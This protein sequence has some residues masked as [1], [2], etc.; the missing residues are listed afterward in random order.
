MNT[1]N[2][3]KEKKKQLIDV[4]GSSSVESAQKGGYFYTSA[5]GYE[6]MFTMDAFETLTSE[7]FL[8]LISENRYLNDK[9]GVAYGKLADNS[10][11]GFVMEIGSKEG[12]HFEAGQRYTVE[13]TENNGIG[14]PM[15][16]SKKI[17]CNERDSVLL[18]LECDRLPERF[19]FNRCQSVRIELDSVSGIY[20][21]KKA[22]ESVRGNEGVYILRGSVV[23]FRHIY[24][25]YEG[26]DYYLVSEDN[27]DDGLVYLS[28]NDLIILNGTNLFEGR[29][30][31]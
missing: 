2:T 11:W 26:S 14:L 3:L 5:D 18:V 29:I 7:S 30:L 8:K 28:P 9:G 25:V 10:Q 31:E 17:D 19:E 4:S 13:F 20:V 22:V 1:L 23:H 16:L 21:P 6:E 15:S 12:D 27:P 24:V